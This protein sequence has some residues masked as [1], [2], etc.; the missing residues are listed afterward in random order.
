MIDAANITAVLLAAGQS[1]R[2][3]AD[4]KLLAPLADEPLA[5]HA[6]RRIAELAPGRRIAVC[7]NGDGTLAAMLSGL[8]FDIAVNADA[9]SGLSQSLALGIAAAARGPELAALVCLADMPFVGT[10]H[11]QSLLA[12][13]DPVS[14]PVVASSDGE[15]A[16]PPALFDRAL[17][18]RLRAS[19]G[20]RGGKALLSDAA[21][22]MASAGELADID[23][24][25]DLRRN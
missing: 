15:T 23:R 25:D 8:G 6:A 24:P 9:T 4:D 13:F 14:A 1:R 7:S 10:R 17:F 22:V 21:L 16:M 3:G 12:R 20:D 19:E 5:L 11:L 18:D 2:F